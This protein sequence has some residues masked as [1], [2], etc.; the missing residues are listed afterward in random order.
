MIK[1]F[2]LI[3]LLVVIAIIAILAA[4]LLPALSASREAAK[5]SHC[6]SNLKQIGVYCALYAG[7]WEDYFPPSR[8]S[9]NFYRAMHAYSSEPDKL[10]HRTKNNVYLC[11]N[12]VERMEESA[13]RGDDQYRYYSYG[14]NTFTVCDQKL[15]GSQV[16]TVLF[17]NKY[18]TLF[19]PTKTLFFADSSQYGEGV[20]SNMIHYSVRFNSSSYPFKE[21][22]PETNGMRLRHNKTS[23]VMMCD[24]HVEVGTFDKYRKASKGEY[25]LTKG[26]KF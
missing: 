18:S 24:G 7:D 17:R 2:T 14:M 10:W 16:T 13:K 20:A 5:S 9:N 25:Y 4:M 19:D 3:E 15:S 12:D 22:T 21:E 1:K 23:N 11:P 26:G 8:D 6:Q